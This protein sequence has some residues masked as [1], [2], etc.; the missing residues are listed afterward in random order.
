M[1]SSYFPSASLHSP[2]P[3]GD[4]TPDTVTG[5]VFTGTSVAVNA[6]SVQQGINVLGSNVPIVQIGA[7]TG[8]CMQMYWTGG[9]A[10]VGT[11]GNLDPLT[12]LASVVHFNASALEVFRISQSG[13]VGIITMIN[14][15]TSASGLTTGMVYSNSGILT[16]VP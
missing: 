10:Q 7:S 9:G 5:T 1:A 14:I 15:P 3:I 12:I 2:G 4:V 8:H 11:F 16:I 13:G 6:G